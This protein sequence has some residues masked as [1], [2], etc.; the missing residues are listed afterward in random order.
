M[1]EKEPS[2]EAVNILLETSNNALRNAELC[3][4]EKRLDTTVREA[5]LAIENAANASRDRVT[6]FQ[7]HFSNSFSNKGYR[8]TSQC[9]SLT[10]KI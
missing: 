3:F 6:A 7:N 5:I 2:L 4:R 1:A 10:M 8:S 9:L